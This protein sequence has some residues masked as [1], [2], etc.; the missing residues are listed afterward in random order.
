MTFDAGYQVVRGSETDVLDR[1]TDALAAFP[2]DHVVRLT[3]DC[4][5]ADPV[6]IEGVLG[7]IDR[8]ATRNTLKRVP[9]DLSCG[10]LVL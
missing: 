5:L 4:P 9:A 10:W 3:A 8:G 7:Q 1:F 2:A 6:L